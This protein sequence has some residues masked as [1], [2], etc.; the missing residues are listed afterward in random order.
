[1]EPSPLLTRAPAKNAATPKWPFVVAGL[2]FFG[3]LFTGNFF[4]DRSIPA[5]GDITIRK[6]TEPLQVT[7][8]APRPTSPYPSGWSVYFDPTL[9]VLPNEQSYSRAYLLKTPEAPAASFDLSIETPPYQFERPY[10]RTSGTVAPTRAGS[11][12]KQDPALLIES[13]SIRIAEKPLLS[14]VGIDGDLSNRPILSLPDFP[15]VTRTELL[16]PSEISLGVDASGAVRMALLDHSCGDDAVDELGLKLAREVSFAPIAA[17]G[18]RLN[19]GR[20]RVSWIVELKAPS[21]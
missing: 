15:K 7:L 3:L 10:F 6:T 2:I 12:S 11:W 4:V 9:M 13:P 8:D 5:E 14:I 17:Q 16:T 1:M 21:P 20:L 19:W 18:E